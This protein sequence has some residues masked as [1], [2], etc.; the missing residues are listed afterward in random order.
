MVIFIL[1]VIVALWFLCPVERLGVRHIIIFLLASFLVLSEIY[2]ESLDISWNVYCLICTGCQP[3][4]KHYHPCNITLLTEVHIVK[5]KVFPVVMYRCDSWTIKKAEYQRTHAFEQWCWRLL[6]IPWTTRRSNQSILRK[7][8]NEYSLEG[9]MLKLKLQYLGHLMWWTDSSEIALMLGKIEGR[10]RR[11]QQR[12]SWLDGIIY[13]MDM[14]LDN[15]QELVVNREAWCAAARGVSKSRKQLSNWTE[16][17]KQDRGA[18]ST[19]NLLVP[20]S[21]TYYLLKLSE[22]NVQSLSHQSMI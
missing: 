15:L 18:H 11:G 10:R 4:H 3:V 14:S 7:I 2:Q 19:S 5:G 21:R 9:L 22:V 6:R 12:M 17:M 16:L 8:N 1:T 13:S 20:W